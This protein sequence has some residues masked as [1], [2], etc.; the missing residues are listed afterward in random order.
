MPDQK[1]KTR[2]YYSLGY[3]V[4]APILVIGSE[5]LLLVTQADQHLA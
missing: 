5:L 4:E 2:D 3:E 1:G